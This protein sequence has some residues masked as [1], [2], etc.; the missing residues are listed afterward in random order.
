MRRAVKKNKKPFE[1]MGPTDNTHRS[2]IITLG[3][4]T[5]HSDYKEYESF[6]IECSLLP[7]DPAFADKSEGGLSGSHAL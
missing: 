4:H 6:F 1:R 5:P 7:I 2:F 3:L